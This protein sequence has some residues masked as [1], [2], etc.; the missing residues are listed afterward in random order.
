[1]PDYFIF[2]LLFS[3]IWLLQCREAV[4]IIH[5]Q[6]TTHK[7]RD[8]MTPSQL[9][10]N[11]LQ[12]NPSSIFFTRENM[13]LSGDT[14]KNYG[15]RSWGAFWVLYRKNP[16]NGGSIASVY[17]DKVTFAIVKPIF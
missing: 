16:V 4:D 5:A 13:K 12:A 9:K 6:R 2:F 8:T 1:M 14:M 10:A 7:Q 15:V 3:C 11:F 17:F